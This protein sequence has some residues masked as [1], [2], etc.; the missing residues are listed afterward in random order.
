MNP[1]VYFIYSAAIRRVYERVYEPGF[2]TDKY[3]KIFPCKIYDEFSYDLKVINLV[4][5]VLALP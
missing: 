4:A 1:G 3:G 2:N 5:I